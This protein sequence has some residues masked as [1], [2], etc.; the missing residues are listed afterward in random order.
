METSP[1]SVQ[2]KPLTSICAMRV[3]GHHSSATPIKAL[4]SG[5]RIA[6]GG[7][8]MSILIDAGHSMHMINFTVK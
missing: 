7:H 5:R 1:F 8:P 6:M 4:T 2:G 3:G